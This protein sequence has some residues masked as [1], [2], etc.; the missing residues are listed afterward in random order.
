MTSLRARYLLLLLIAVQAFLGGLIG[1]ASAPP[2]TTFPSF[3]ENQL[4]EVRQIF[5][6]IDEQNRTVKRSPE[7]IENAYRALSIRQYRSLD[8]AAREAIKPFVRN[9]EVYIIVHP[10][11]YAFYMHNYERT[12]LLADNASPFPQ[13]NLVERLKAVLPQDVVNYRV[14]GEQ[15]RLIRDFLEYMSVRKQLVIIVLPHD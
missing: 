8:A 1:C 3:T 2:K 11:Y 5:A 12:P 10:A 4:A 9:N 13:E 6:R 7:W 14:M 15:E